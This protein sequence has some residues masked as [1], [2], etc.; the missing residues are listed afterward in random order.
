MDRGEFG[1]IL[2]AAV[3][4]SFDFH[5]RTPEYS[6]RLDLTLQ[7]VARQNVLQAVSHAALHFAIAAAGTSGESESKN[8]ERALNLRREVLRLLYI[9]L[10]PDTTEQQLVELWKQQNDVNK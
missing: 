9:Q 3:S 8:A 5:Q 4:G 1:L 6:T 2:Q 7:A 10:K